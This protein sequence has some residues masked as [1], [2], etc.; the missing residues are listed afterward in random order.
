MKYFGEYL[1]EK[2]IVSPDSLVQAVLQ[3]TQSQPLAAQIAFEKKLFSADEMIKIFSFQQ[4]HQLDFFAAGHATG[5]LTTDK[6]QS[7]EQ[8]LQQHHLPL[9][10]LLIKSGSVGAKDMV[11]ALDEFLSTAKVPSVPST[12]NLKTGTTSGHGLPS[13]TFQK[14]DP[15][16]SSELQGALSQSKITE[17][18]NVLHLVKQN[19]NVKELVQEFLQDVLKSIL[20]FRGL[21][22]AAQAQVLDHI[23]SLLES[24]IVK[25]LRAETPDSK[26]I[27]DTLVPS[28]EKA[29]NFCSS[30]KDSIAKN[31]SEKMFWE[32]DMNQE[33]Y[34]AFAKNLTEHEV[35]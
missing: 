30:M 11:H 9:A 21:A 6:K 16:F 18:V 25:V 34:K 22:K 29:L 33:E 13:F 12:A 4:E 20:T 1:V 32:Q 26:F 23:C 5:L 19:A 35:K 24:A 3:Q 2:K 10:G 7:I 28:I 8:E 17:V 27:T 15:T 31:Q 14:I